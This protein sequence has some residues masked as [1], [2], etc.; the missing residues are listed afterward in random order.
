[1]LTRL[2]ILLVR[3]WQ[4]GPSVVLP[5][6]CRYQPSCSAYAITALRRYGAVKGGWLAAKR[7]GR[8]HPF[9]G[10]GPDPVP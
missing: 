2:L 10:Y 6:S 3:A 8:C 5:S 1:M 9:G 4:I 7:I